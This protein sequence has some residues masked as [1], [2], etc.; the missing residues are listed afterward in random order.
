MDGP[1]L[2]DFKS[3]S[4]LDLRR[5]ERARGVRHSELCERL[6]EEAAPL[7]G[8]ASKELRLFPE[9]ESQIDEEIDPGEYGAESRACRWFACFIFMLSSSTKGGH[10]SMTEDEFI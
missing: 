2:Y 1:R 7:V 9:R 8:R 3:W 5:G 6:S 4:A 10:M